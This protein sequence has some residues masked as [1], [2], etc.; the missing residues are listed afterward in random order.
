MTQPK[1]KYPIESFGPELM[2]ILLKAG[3]GETVVLNFPHRKDARRFQQRLHMLRGRMRE[4]KHELTDVVARART[5]LRYEGGPEDPATLTVAQ[6]DSEFADVLKEAKIE[7][8]EGPTTSGV[9]APKLDH[10]PLE[11]L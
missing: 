1:S 7:R 5:S 4:L 2:Q 11:D 10:D 3:R 9:A 6:Y 8:A